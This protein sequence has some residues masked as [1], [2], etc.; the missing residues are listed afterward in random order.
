MKTMSLR[1]R[2]HRAGSRRIAKIAL[3]S[4]TC[5][6]LIVAC[7][8]ITGNDEDE[9]CRCKGAKEN[10]I[11]ATGEPDRKD[12]GDCLIFDCAWERW[13]YDDLK[14]SVYFEWET[15]PDEEC[16]CEVRWRNE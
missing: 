2:L 6:L 5:L 3:C 1:Q 14:R 13:Y 11:V 15:D 4:F 8:S 9:V 10:M 12:R 7:D 16:Y